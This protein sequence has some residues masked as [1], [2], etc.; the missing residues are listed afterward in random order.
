VLCVGL[1]E[2]SR[3][4]LISTIKRYAEEISGLKWKLAEKDAQLMGG[5][6]ACV[7]QCFFTLYACAFVTLCSVSMSKQVQKSVFFSTFEM[8]ES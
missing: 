6:G 1:Q 4:E 7:N 2:A 5:F 8:Q 3:E